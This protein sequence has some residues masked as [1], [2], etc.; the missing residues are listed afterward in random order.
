MDEQRILINTFNN[1]GFLEYTFSD[2]ELKP[3]REEVQEIKSNFKQFEQSK[4]NN[5]LAG[6]IEFE[7]S[8]HKSKERINELMYPLVGIYER[9]YNYSVSIDILSGPLPL[10]LTTPW[11]NFQKKGEFN[12]THVHGGIYSFVLYLSVPYNIEDEMK[13]NS[14]VESNKKVPA[15]F[16][17]S[18]VNTLGQISFKTIPV[19]R[20]Y[21]NT[22][23]FF[24]SKMVHAVY[25][26][27]TS[28]EYRISVS[29]NFKLIV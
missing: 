21:E 25:P 22:C 27:Y 18:Y 6:N 15:H 24:P 10:E 29:G 12:P 8:L 3:I 19:D 4:C 1:Y 2:D 5:T 13:R 26:F 16:E 11:V 9:I 7:Y 17:F 14:T 20:K 28:D 23:L